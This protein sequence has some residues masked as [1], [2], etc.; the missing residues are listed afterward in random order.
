VAHNTVIGAYV[1]ELAGSR[2]LLV[3]YEDFMSR[4]KEVI[5]SIL[6]L[7][8]EP[9]GLAEHPFLDAHTVFVK[10]SHT[11]SG[12]PRRFETGAVELRLDD[13]WQSRASLA[14]KVGVA[15]LASPLLKRMG[16][17]FRPGTSHGMA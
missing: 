1:R 12:N 16:Y 10:E 6:R 13:E 14:L 15:A 3:Q 7:I 2:Y 8:D 4:P 5:R 9:V 11:A 17:G